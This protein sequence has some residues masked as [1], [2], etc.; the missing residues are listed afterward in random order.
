MYTRLWGSL[1]LVAGNMC[2]LTPSMLDVQLVDSCLSLQMRL[3][4]L[5]QGVNMTHHHRRAIGIS[6]QSYQRRTGMDCSFTP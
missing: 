1:V 5:A 4:Y 3:G 6:N 2:H